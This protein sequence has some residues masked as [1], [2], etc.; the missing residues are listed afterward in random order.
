[1]LTPVVQFE[2]EFHMRNWRQIA[3][4]IGLTLSVVNAVALT[5]K[6]YVLPDRVCSTIPLIIFGY[7]FLSPDRAKKP[8][9]EP[10]WWW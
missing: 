4:G 6:T 1:V 3:T 8:D 7:L 9:T 10:P 5:S 2:S